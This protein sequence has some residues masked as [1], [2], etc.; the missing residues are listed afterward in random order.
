MAVSSYYVE[1]AGVLIDPMLPE[2]GLGAFEGR[3]RPRQVV[4]S[5]GNHIRDTRSFV[6]A[7]GCT[8]VVSREGAERIGGKLEAVRVDC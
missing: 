6:E 2:A 7:F 8:V 4:L 3:S 5:S 1:P